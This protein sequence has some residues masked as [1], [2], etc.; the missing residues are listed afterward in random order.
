[1]GR[2]ADKDE[3]GKKG[4]CTM[5][6]TPSYAATSRSSIALLQCQGQHEA[7]GVGGE[8]GRGGG[9]GQKGNSSTTGWAWSPEMGCHMFSGCDQ[10][11]HLTRDHKVPHLDLE[12]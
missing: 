3:K 9:G 7:V 4:G 1:M 10:P 2:E 6:S 8:E 12:G 11:M 5:T